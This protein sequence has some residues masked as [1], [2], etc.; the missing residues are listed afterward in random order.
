M[1]SIFVL[2]KTFSIAEKFKTTVAAHE[3]VGR[4]G[5]LPKLYKADARTRTIIVEHCGMSLQDRGPGSYA[6]DIE[7]AMMKDQFKVQHRMHI[8]HL[9][10]KN[11]CRDVNTL[12]LQQPPQPLLRKPSTLYLQFE[13]NFASC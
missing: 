3:R 7:G 13:S 12:H 9:S 8:P 2:E 6:N 4:C 11:L 10:Q 1:G 5:C